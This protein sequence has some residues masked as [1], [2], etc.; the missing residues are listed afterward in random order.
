ME[1]QK[2]EIS[3]VLEDVKHHFMASRN[4]QVI[5]FT[6]ERIS[7]TILYELLNPILEMQSIKRSGPGISLTFK[8][9]SNG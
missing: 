6:Q 8:A 1:E 4:G 9:W 5:A 3:K 7:A 2:Q